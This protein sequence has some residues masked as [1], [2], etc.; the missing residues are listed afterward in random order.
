MGCVVRVGVLASL[1]LRVREARR[2][3]PETEDHVDLLAHKV[4][5]DRRATQESL[6][7]KASKGL[8][9]REVFRV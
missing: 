3:R 9:A 4:S 7:Q 2:A 1:V 5:P 8:S 6:G